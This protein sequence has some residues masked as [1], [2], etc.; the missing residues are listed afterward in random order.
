MF[1]PASN[2][3]ATKLAAAADVDWRTA[4]KA[5]RHGVSAVRGRPGERIAEAAKALGISLP[6]PQ[7]AAA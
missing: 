6:E 3:T 2:R 5:L 7:G 1:Q 4:R